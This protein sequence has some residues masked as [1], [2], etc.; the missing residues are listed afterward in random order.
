MTADSTALVEIR[1]A[2]RKFLADDVMLTGGV[3][4]LRDDSSFL[5]RNL[6]DS[7]GLLELLAFIEESWGVPVDDDEIIPENLDSIDLVAAF[8]ARKQ[9]QKS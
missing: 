6:L 1:R 9:G 3:E 5:E 8:V 2:V 7:T 4:D